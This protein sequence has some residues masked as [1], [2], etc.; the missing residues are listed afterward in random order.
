MIATIA[1]VLAVTRRWSLRSWLHKGYRPVGAMLADCDHRGDRRRAR[2]RA[3][4]ALLA[5][6][7]ALCEGAT[8]DTL[9][10]KGRAVEAWPGVDMNRSFTP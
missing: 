5:D 2:E 6:L 1:Q 3:P 9:K 8:T 4:L 7:G 10:A